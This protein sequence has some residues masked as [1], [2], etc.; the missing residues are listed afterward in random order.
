MKDNL[1]KDVLM[2]VLVGLV[3]GCVY[4]GIMEAM[5]GLQHK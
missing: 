1:F 2:C 4:L 5:D 3:F